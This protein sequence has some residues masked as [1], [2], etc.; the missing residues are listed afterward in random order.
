MSKEVFL[1]TE[2]NPDIA[3]LPVRCKERPVKGI[4][5]RVDWICGGILTRYIVEGRVKE[6]S[7][8]KFLY[9]NPTKFKFPIV[10]LFYSNEKFLKASIEDVIKDISPNR[11]FVDISVVSCSIE[12][13][14]NG[15]EVFIY[16]SINL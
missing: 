5:G 9:Y 2:L 15:V 13:N 4:A 14:V 12:L 1:M 7:G 11:V 8:E 3:I 16:S 6:R 10:F